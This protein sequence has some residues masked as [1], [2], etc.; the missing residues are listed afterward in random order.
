M[1]KQFDAKEIWY[2]YL[3]VKKAHDDRLA[4]DLKLDEEFTKILKDLYDKLV[5]MVRENAKE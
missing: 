4:S 5:D 3:C 2:L 1:P